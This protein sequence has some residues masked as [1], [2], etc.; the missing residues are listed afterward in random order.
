MLSGAIAKIPINFSWHNIC[1][2]CLGSVTVWLSFKLFAGHWQF[3]GIFCTSDGNILTER[4]AGI[5]DGWNHQCRINRAEKEFSMCITF[6]VIITGS[7]K[8]INKVWHLKLLLLLMLWFDPFV[9][10]LCIADVHWHTGLTVL[11]EVLS[12]TLVHPLAPPTAKHGGLYA[13]Y[14]LCSTY[15]AYEFEN[16]LLPGSSQVWM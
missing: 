13:L 10:L 12:L 4:T 15:C 1:G 16:V 11:F 5:N 2:S 9:Y 8:R 14:S 7:V 6:I 3:I